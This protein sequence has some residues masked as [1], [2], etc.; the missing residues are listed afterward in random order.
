MSE[1]RVLERSYADDLEAGNS[2]LEQHV[3]CTFGQKDSDL[4]PLSLEAIAACMSGRCLR[5]GKIQS[6]K[7]LVHSTMDR[8]IKLFT[9][10]PLS[11]DATQVIKTI[12]LLFC[13]YLQ[14]TPA[15]KKGAKNSRLLTSYLSMARNIQLFAKED[16]V[17]PYVKYWVDKHLAQDG[18]E[19]LNEYPIDNAFEALPLFS[20]F[21]K[22]F[23][24]RRKARRDIRFFYSLQKGCKQAWPKLSKSYLVKA[25]DSHEADV[26]RSPGPLQQDVRDS[27]ARTSHEVFKGIGESSFTKFS[28]TGSACL[29]VGRNGGGTLSCTTR[30]VYPWDSCSET[31]QEGVKRMG[32]LPTL[33]QSHTEWRNANFDFLL[34][35]VMD[36]LGR[37]DP[38][39]ESKLLDVAILPIPEPG[40]FRIISE[41]CS[42]L[43]NVLQPLQG[44]MLSAWKKHP[45]G[46]MAE[47]GDLTERI[48]LLD[49]ED[50]D[51]WAS[52]DYKAATDKLSIEASLVAMSGIPQDTW[53]LLGTQSLRAGKVSYSWVKEE[54]NILRPSKTITRNSGQ[55]MGHPLSFPL[56][57][58][59]NLSVWRLGL[60]RWSEDLDWGDASYFNELVTRKEY[61]EKHWNSVIING[62][63]MAAK[64]NSS[65]YQHLLQ[66]AKDH[67]FTLS[68]GKNY[69]S[70]RCVMINSQ[71][72][73]HERSGMVRRGYLNQRILLGFSPKKGESTALPTQIGLELNKM[74]RL[75]PIYASTIPIAFERFK[76]VRILRTEPNWFLPV[77]LGGYGV[78]PTFGSID[79]KVTR[80]QRIIAAHFINDPKLSLFLGNDVIGA[81][82]YAA[83]EKSVVVQE[84]RSVFNLEYPLGHSQNPITL[85]PPRKTPLREHSV[86]EIFA[87][88]KMV[89][90][91]YVP[92]PSETLV[93]EDPWLERICGLEQLHIGNLC[94]LNFDFENLI[95]FGV[96]SI[97]L[98]HRLRPVSM[99]T[100]QHY[101]EPRYYWSG[102]PTCPRLNTLRWGREAEKVKQEWGY[103][104]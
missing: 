100:I 8:I 17:Q 97:R 72:F 18:F 51:L 60:K 93:H 21:L 5:S 99:E 81:K 20:G 69:A 35:N 101:W 53:R 29:E 76:D 30:F 64:V 44:A 37:S 50:W 7:P 66:S 91:D 47:K 94:S 10:D 14:G 82:T 46:T 45:S 39:H 89:A 79:S 75:N 41:G 4:K 19:D 102:V 31:T 95:R 103:T 25:L 65:L 33:H 34:E 70:Q 86:F 77:H 98:Q 85:P 16:K 43:Y 83:F 59:I 22:T 73:V 26:T 49:V 90:G 2:D 36:E 62:D 11:G 96:R 32:L 23:V 15:L 74:C 71:V 56:L 13:V 58:V 38:E 87:K 52:I 1:N 6:V 84:C 48:K 28:P 24:K 78:D 68:A 55:L 80:M 40:K 12:V 3:G 42:R 67:G 54:D 92:L 27:I 57:C 61:I 88:A 9:E 104:L 63:D